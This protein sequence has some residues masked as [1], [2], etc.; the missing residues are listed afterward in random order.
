MVGDRDERYRDRGI[1]VLMD[2]VDRSTGTEDRDWIEVVENAGSL[3]TGVIARMYVG[4]EV[5]RVLRDRG[6]HD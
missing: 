5:I 4:E 2:S 6:H 3:E 1:L